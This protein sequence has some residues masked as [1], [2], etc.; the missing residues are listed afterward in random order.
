MENTLSVLIR[1]ISS[2]IRLEW[3]HKIH[4]ASMV[5]S[6]ISAVKFFVQRIGV[7]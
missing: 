4:C 5:L 2:V 1:I 3:K 6:Q 7:L